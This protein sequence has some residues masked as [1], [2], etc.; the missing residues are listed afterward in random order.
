MSHF[1]T[2]REASK[3]L[4]IHYHTLYALAERKEIETLKVGER[5]LYNVEKYLKEHGIKQTTIRRKVCYCRVSSNKQKEDLHR[6]MD[7]MKEIY[8]T[9]EM[10]S[11]IASGL[12]YE[13]NGLKK[14]IKYIIDGELEVLVIAYKDRLVRFGYE[15]IEWILKEYSKG[16]IIILHKTEED[17]P[18]EEITKDIISIMNIYVAKLNGMRKYKTGQKTKDK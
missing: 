1:L 2:R 7:E 14:I 10:I 5:Q 4:G 18:A 11:D 15:M 3:Q 9:Y 13:R 16:E 6:Q 8:P 12:N 17:T